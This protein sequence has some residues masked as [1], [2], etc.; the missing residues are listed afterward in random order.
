MSAVLEHF[1]SARLAI[2]GEGPLQSELTEQIKKLGLNEVVQFLGFQQN[3]WRYL[4]HAD[5]FVLPSRYEGLPNVLLET[6]TLGTPVVA[7]DCLG[8]TR[9]VQESGAKMVLVPP[10][11]PAALAEAIVSVCR[12]RRGYQDSMETSRSALSRFDLDRVVEE[13]AALF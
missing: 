6:L 11:D 7:T 10:E 9:E 8:A 4:K 3:P 2:L 12:R 13:Y 1:P 5:L